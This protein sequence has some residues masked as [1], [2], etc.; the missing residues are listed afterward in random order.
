MTGRGR[1]LFYEQVW[2]ERAGT[3]LAERIADG[4]DGAAARRE[5]ESGGQAA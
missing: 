5:R 3:W 4:L 1:V 2:R